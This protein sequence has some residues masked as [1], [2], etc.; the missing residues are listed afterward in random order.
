M[1]TS[2]VQNAYKR[3]YINTIHSPRRLTKYF[4]LQTLFCS[5]F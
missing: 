5:V 3:C 4:A 1:S 2:R